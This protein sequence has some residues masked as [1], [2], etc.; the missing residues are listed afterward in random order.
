[1]HKARGLQE[2][3]D[4][5]DFMDRA[6]IAAL[7]LAASRLDVNADHREYGERLAAAAFNIA[8]HMLNERHLRYNA[9][10]KQNGV[11]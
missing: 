9:I 1:M 7:P 6:A 11:A 8:C 2:I 3:R 10:F 4:Q 5:L